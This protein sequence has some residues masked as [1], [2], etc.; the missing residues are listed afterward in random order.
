MRQPGISMSAG[1]GVCIRRIKMG[2]RFFSLL[3]FIAGWSCLRAQES[4]P[5]PEAFVN[6]VAHVLVDSSFN[7]YYLLSGTDSCRFVR[8]DYEEWSKYHLFEPVPIGVLNELAEKVYLSRYPY[9]WK[10]ERMPAAIC[11]TRRAA[12]SILSFN[13]AS[14]DDSTLSRRRRKKD[15]LQRVERWKQ[16]PAEQKM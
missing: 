14:G 5:S 12:D 15:Y 2:K 3:F 16:L 9:F 6:E 4:F 10:Q 13:P 8:Y 11:I 1:R 7:R